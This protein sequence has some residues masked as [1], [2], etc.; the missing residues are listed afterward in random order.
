MKTLPN[1]RVIKLGSARELT[2]SVGGTKSPE[3]EAPIFLRLV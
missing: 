3:I 1:V 2:Q